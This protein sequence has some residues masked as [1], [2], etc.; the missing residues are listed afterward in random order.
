MVTNVFEIDNVVENNRVVEKGVWIK[1][2]NGKTAKVYNVDLETGEIRL[3]EA[4]PSEAGLVL[5]PPKTVKKIDPEVL[6][7]FKDHWERV[8]RVIEN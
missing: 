4:E 6:S 8:V 3:Y 7:R 2:S 5:N 1:I